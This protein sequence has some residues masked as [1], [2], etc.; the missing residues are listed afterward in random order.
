MRTTLDIDDDVL[1][2][3]KELAR[4]EKKT[5]GEIISELVRKALTNQAS[6]RAGSTSDQVVEK[7]GF[8]LFPAR[9][10]PPLT[11]EHIRQIQCEIDRKEVED[12]VA[13]RR[14]RVD[15]PA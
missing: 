7:N 4:A 6:A 15:R 5:A 13:V 11:E 3:A 10:G 12:A 1:A 9:D 8:F 2:V 14:Q